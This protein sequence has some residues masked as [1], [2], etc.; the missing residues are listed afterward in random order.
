MAQAGLDEGVERLQ[1]FCT[2]L[3]ETGAQLQADTSTFGNLERALD[4]FEDTV[5][6]TLGE[7]TEHL[8]EAAG[9]LDEAQE[10]AAEALRS[11]VEAADEGSGTRVAAAE[12]TIADSGDSVEEGLG[13]GRQDLAVAFSDLATAGFDVLDSAVDELESGAS[14]RAEETGRAL[15]ALEEE[16]RDWQRQVPE[17]YDETARSID[18]AS[19]S[20]LQEDGGNLESDAASC[21]YGWSAEL[22]AALDQQAGELGDPL[23]QAYDELEAEVRSRI[24]AYV[25]TTVSLI[26]DTA[27]L[28]G[29]ESASEV[30]TTAGNAEDDSLEGL[31]G[32][33]AMAVEVLGAGDEM[34]ASLEPMIDDLTVAKSIAAEIDRL[35]NALDQ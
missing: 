22:P 33:L 7:L 3:G 9:V 15:D 21:T 27:D 30:D 32:E 11:L 23:Q 24:D 17:S 20:L 28:I 6:E 25:S 5:D 35:L 1:E 16:L 2:L 12:S 8:D 26:Q 4:E 10:D 34:A 14:S 18:E 29:R 13:A 19:E 31:T